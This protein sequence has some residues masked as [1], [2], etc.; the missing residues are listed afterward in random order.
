MNDKNFELYNK[1]ISYCAVDDD[2][3][4]EFALRELIISA[5]KNRDYKIY[6]GGGYEYLTKNIIRLYDVV[7]YITLAD[8][9]Y[10]MICTDNSEGDFCI[11][12]RCTDECKIVTIKK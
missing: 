6:Y 10:F 3:K 12:S 2:A 5:I 9:V 8:D 1:Y 4:Q 11:L 7:A